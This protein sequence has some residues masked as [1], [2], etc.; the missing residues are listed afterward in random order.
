MVTKCLSARAKTKE[1]AIQVCLMFVEIEEQEAVLEALLEGLANKQ[2]KIVA[3]SVQTIT[4]IVQY[5]PVGR[6]G[7]WGTQ[8]SLILQGLW[9]SGPQHKGS[10]GKG[11]DPV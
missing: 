8:V 5:V 11:A 3:G 1:S 6:G 2:P 9:C 4:R 10:D 7:G